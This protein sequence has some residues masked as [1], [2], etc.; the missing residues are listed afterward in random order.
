MSNYKQYRQTA[1]DFYKKN[2]SFNSARI[3]RDLISNGGAPN[4]DV[5]YR[6]VRKWIASERAKDYRMNDHEA[7]EKE[8]EAIGIPVEDVK[9]YWHKGE[10]FSI[11]VRNEQ[12]NTMQDVLNGI[13]ANMDNHSPSYEV[14]KRKTITDPHLLVVD[15]ADV[16]IGKLCSAFE[17]GESYDNQIAV[18]RVKDGVQGI[19]D[20]VQGFNI[21]KILYIVGN[22][23]LH[24]DT[25]KNTTTAGTH[26]DTTGM[27]YDN[28]MIG[29]QLDVD[30][31]ESLRLIAPVHVQY[32]PSNHDYTN[33]FF[34]A[35]ALSSWFRNCEDVTFNVSIAHRKYFTYGQNLIGTTHGDG[36]K[37]AD[38]PLLMAQEASEHWHNCK[39]RYVYIHHI[40]HKMSKDYGS[41]CVESLRSPSGTDSWHSR[42]GYAHSPK[43]IEGFL[44]HPEHGQ[45]ARITNLF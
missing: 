11:N 29:F 1:V 4:D 7:L 13:I 5:F 24:V 20:K 25:P 23:K 21:D 37:T 41:V 27:W 43:A 45:I 15:P 9:N 19:L 2:P 28:Y 17:T 38:L 26:Q 39:H 44:H 36:A 42:N 16:H 12:T 31:I 32:D 8:C 6:L 22:D 33:G 35:Q 10:H 3:A 18:N 14:I 34:L 30:I 40:H